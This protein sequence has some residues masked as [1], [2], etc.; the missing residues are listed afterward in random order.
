MKAVLIEFR[1]KKLDQMSIVFQLGLDSFSY[2]VDKSKQ[3]SALGCGLTRSR[4]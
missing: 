4:L 3:A 2:G 1:T